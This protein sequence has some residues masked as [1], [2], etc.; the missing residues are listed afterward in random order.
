MQRLEARQIFIC[1]IGDFF[2]FVHPVDNPPSIEKV[3]KTLSDVIGHFATCK[4]ARFESVHEDEQ[5]D[6]WIH[7]QVEIADEIKAEDG[8]KLF[9]ISLP[10]QLHIATAIVRVISKVVT[11]PLFAFSEGL[12]HRF[13]GLSSFPFGRREDVGNLGF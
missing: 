9:V 12:A 6:V 7:R 1:Q 5:S 13:E 8:R 3:C 11:A 2:M 10:S 4:R